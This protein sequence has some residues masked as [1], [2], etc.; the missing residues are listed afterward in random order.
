MNA[1]VAA[2]SML[3]RHPGAKGSSSISTRSGGASTMLVELDPDEG[4]G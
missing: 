4:P 3:C 2:P 1:A